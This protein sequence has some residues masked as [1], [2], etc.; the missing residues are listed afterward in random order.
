MLNAVGGDTE[1]QSSL[2]VLLRNIVTSFAIEGEQLNVDSVRSSLARRLG[3]SEEGNQ[4]GSS[5]PS[6]DTE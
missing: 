5:L 1:A 2:D 4:P 6:L 3:I